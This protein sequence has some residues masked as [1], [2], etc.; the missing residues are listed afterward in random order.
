MCFFFRRPAVVHVGDEA[1][2][3]RLEADV[4]RLEGVALNKGFREV[5]TH[6]EGAVGIEVDGEGPLG[7]VAK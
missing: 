5:V 6:G 4:E 3:E 1:D 2:V 7:V